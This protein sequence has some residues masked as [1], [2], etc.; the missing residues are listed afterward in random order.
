[1]PEITS[2]FENWPEYCTIDFTYK[3][4]H[5]N[6]PVGL[7]TVLDGNGCTEVAFVCTVESESKENL[8]WF[9]DLIKSRY[10]EVCSKI[11][12]FMTDK[13]QTIRDVVKTKFGVPVYICS[14]HVADTF[15]RQ[16]HRDKMDIKTQQREDLLQI[17]EKMM[18]ASNEEKYIELYD[19][20]CKTA[21]DVV[22]TY[23]DE[24]WHN[25]HAEWVRGLMTN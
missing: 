7:V 3:L 8:S 20:F 2:I 17:L 12:C 13:D 10:P 18:Y 1:M 25:I 22:R 11:Q 24:N 6:F 4:L 9:L 14:Y 16:I 5:L 21:P 23:F 19:E 15:K